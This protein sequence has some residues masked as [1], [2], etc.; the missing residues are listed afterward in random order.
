MYD[1]LNNQVGIS[2]KQWTQALFD[3][4]DISAVLASPIWK[5][6]KEIHKELQKQIRKK[7]RA[8]AGWDMGTARQ[9]AAMLFDI[10]LNN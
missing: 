5:D 8:L 9:H 1:Y 7:L 4:D 3:D 2:A 6:K 10:L